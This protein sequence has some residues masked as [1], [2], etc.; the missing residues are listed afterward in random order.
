MNNSTN[1]KVTPVVG[2]KK[3]QDRH[4]SEWQDTIIIKKGD[5]HGMRKAIEE[6]NAFYKKCGID[7]P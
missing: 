4:D 3:T 7:M 2:T 1:H 5:A 6:K